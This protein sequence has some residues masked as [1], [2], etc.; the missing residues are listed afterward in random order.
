[1]LLETLINAT[2]ALTK[3]MS[4]DLPIVLAFR[5]GVMVKTVDP[6]LQSYNDRRNELIKQYSEPDEKGNRQVPPKHMQE[7][8][9][10]LKLVLNEEVAVAGIPEITLK[11]LEGIKMTAQHMSALT[12]WLLKA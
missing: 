7:F 12:P 1:M 11:E 9:D 3:L 2:P 5:L 8:G 4:C 10:K 6:I